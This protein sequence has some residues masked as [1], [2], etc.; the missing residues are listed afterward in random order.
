MACA[1]SSHTVQVAHTAG[2]VNAAG[3]WLDADAYGPALK[4]HLYGAKA[5]SVAA[6]FAMQKYLASASAAKG[7]WEAAFMKLYDK[8]IIEEDAFIAWKDDVSDKTPGKQTALLNTVRWFEWLTS[9]DSEDE[10]DENSSV[11]EALKDIVR[12][13]NSRL[14]R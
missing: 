2:K 8:D 13:D 1:F 4:H 5:A 3:A 14:L 9:A 7:V 10:D 6:L 12:P 11:E